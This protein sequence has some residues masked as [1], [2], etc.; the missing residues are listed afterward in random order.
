MVCENYLLGE[1]AL[2]KLYVG[3]CMLVS[4]LDIA[5]D[6]RRQNAKLGDRR[7]NKKLKPLVRGLH[8]LGRATAVRCGIILWFSRSALET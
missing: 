3:H 4:S 5:Q 6:F 8:L 1:W 7:A 2:H